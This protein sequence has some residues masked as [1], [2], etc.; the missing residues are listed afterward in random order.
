MNVIADIATAIPSIPGCSIRTAHT[1]VIEMESIA[2]IKK[3]P[4]VFGRGICSMGA[5]GMIRMNP[6]LFA[7]DVEIK[8][9]RRPLFPK[10]ENTNPVKNTAAAVATPNLDMKNQWEATTLIQ[11][12]LTAPRN[13]PNRQRNFRSLQ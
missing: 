3:N 10:K 13:P 6:R 11:A 7:T 9:F 1:E 8:T 5:A 12:M 4:T 2:T